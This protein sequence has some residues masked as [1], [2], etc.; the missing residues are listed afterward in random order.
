MDHPNHSHVQA[1][2]RDLRL[3]TLSQMP[4]ALAK[5]IYLAGLRDYN[6]GLY[7]HEGLASRYSD[8]AACEALADCHRQAFR[9]LLSASLE[10]TVQQLES[11]MTGLQTA[12]G[13]FFS[14]W[15]S[16]RPYQIAVPAGTDPLSA[17]FL[18]SNLR[19]ALAILESRYLGRLPAAPAAS[20]RR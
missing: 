10:E 1:A 13:E 5:L 4:V 7:H 20:P 11:Y 17:E 9:D 12:P 6:T 19:V 14:A 15:N 8:E 18:S 3:R 16:L 2:I